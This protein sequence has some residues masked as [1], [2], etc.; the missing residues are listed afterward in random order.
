MPFSRNFVS[1]T[2]QRLMDEQ[3]GEDD[4]AQLLNKDWRRRLR[5]ASETPNAESDT[6]ERR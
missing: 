1:T 3:A 4:I 2:E 5:I 6:L